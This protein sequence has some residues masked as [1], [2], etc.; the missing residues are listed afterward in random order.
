MQE[1]CLEGYVAS[2]ML[3][4]TFR[5]KHNYF[6]VPTMQYMARYCPY[7]DQSNCNITISHIIN[8]ALYL[9]LTSPWR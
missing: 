6:M 5:Q 1:N 3:Q 2:L 9:F 8:L 7:S 4:Y